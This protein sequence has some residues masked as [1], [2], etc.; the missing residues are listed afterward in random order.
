M[1]FTKTA[2][3]SGLVSTLLLTSCAT[4]MHG[5][6]QNIGISSNPAHARVA[7]DGR[8][9]GQTPIIVNLTRKDNHFLRIE[10]PGYMPYEAVFTKQLSGWVFGNVIFGGVIGLAVDAISGGIY[11]L[12]PEQVQAEMCQGQ[13]TCQVNGDN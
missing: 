10:L 3:L 11:K 4:I 5:T 12:T 8:Y 6:R 7:I 2:V 13:M 9:V 1:K